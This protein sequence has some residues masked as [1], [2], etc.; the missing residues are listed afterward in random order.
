MLVMRRWDTLVNKGINKQ[1]RNLI[2]EGFHVIVLI[3]DYLLRPSPDSKMASLPF[4]KSFT[5]TQ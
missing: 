1:Q 3:K 4:A 5:Q 2:M